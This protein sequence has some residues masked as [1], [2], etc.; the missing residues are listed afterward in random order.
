MMRTLTTICLFLAVTTLDAFGAARRAAAEP[1][2]QNQ[3][4]PDVEHLYNAGLYEQAVKVLDDGLRSNPD[5]ADMED[6]RGRCFYQLGD[7]GQAI[8]SLERAVALDP[9]RSESHDW[10]GKAY[11]RKA[12]QSN[13]L[14]AL[15]LAGKAHKEFSEA[16]RLNPSNLSAQRDLISY[17]LNSP[18]IVGGGQERAD[19]QIQALSAVDATEG[20]LARAE[21]DVVHKKFDAADGEYAKLL[22][23]RPR[24]I[25]V[26]FEIAEYY[27]DRGNGE[28]M[29]KAVD[30]AVALG[31]SDL[32]M[33]Y[34]RGVA[35][36]IAQKDPVD[37]ERYLRAYLDSVPANSEL[38][39]R[40]SAREFLGRLYEQEHKLDSAAEQYQAGL[41]LD[42]HNKNLHEDLRRVE[43][44]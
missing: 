17:L 5:N 4:M 10:L 39:P 25:G 9:S 6:E 30:E 20:S 13:P 3:G 35:L 41:A 42:P 21:A 18:G 22:A 24:R 29:Q 1:A 31:P 38:P 26:D 2:S 36:V 32:R 16:V 7:Y 43:R 37:A 34:Y 44:K 8:A 23:A 14:S 15:S 19:E 11:G 40:A 12:E 28:M 33:N 27:R